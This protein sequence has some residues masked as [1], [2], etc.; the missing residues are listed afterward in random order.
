MAHIKFCKDGSIMFIRKD[1][2]TIY[3]MAKDVT[4]DFDDEYD[5]N[6]FD[7]E[8]GYEEMRLKDVVEVFQAVK[9][10]A[11]FTDN[12]FDK[13]VEQVYKNNIVTRK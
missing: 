12:S 7:E 13:G 6:E 4:V 1:E 3:L 9:N 8:Q 2:K 10:T 5:V 11:Y